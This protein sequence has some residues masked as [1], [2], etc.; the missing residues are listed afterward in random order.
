MSSAATLFPVQRKR[1]RGDGS[2]APADTAAH[3]TEQHA[4]T[5]ALGSVLLSSPYVIKT[6]TGDVVMALARAA[7][8][9]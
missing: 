5:L 9:P 8:G 3:V 7:I 1:H 2:K 6:W 4:C